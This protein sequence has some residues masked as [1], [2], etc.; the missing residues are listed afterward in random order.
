MLCVTAVTNA[1]CNFNSTLALGLALV[2]IAVVDW[3]V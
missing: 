2:G 1:L 3:L